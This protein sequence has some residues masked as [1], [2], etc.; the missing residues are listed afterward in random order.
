[1][2][3]E[4]AQAR[5]KRYLTEGRLRLKLVQSRRILAVCRGTGATWS[6]GFMNG[7]WFCECPARTRCSHLWALQL[8]TEVK[9]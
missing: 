3:R 9:Q 2:A 6:C 1:M 4:N 5:G 8:V 7:V